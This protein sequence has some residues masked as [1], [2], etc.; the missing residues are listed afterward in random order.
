M[1]AEVKKPDVKGNSEGSA[2]PAQPTQA[3]ARMAVARKGRRT[4]G[5]YDVSDEGRTNIALLRQIAKLARNA[6]R[7]IERGDGDDEEFAFKTAQRIRSVAGGI[8]NE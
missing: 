2:V 5:D 3:A 4:R 7:S 8:G 1:A 6:V